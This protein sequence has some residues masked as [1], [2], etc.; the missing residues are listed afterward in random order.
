VT[1]PAP[2]IA[3]AAAVGGGGASPLELVSADVLS[4]T[5]VHLVFS[6][7]VA[8]STLVDPTEFRLSVARSHHAGDTFFQA[9]HYPPANCNCRG[10]YADLATCEPIA[11]GT[12]ETCSEV[13]LAHDYTSYSELGPF[14]QLA[15]GA[16]PSEVIAT[17]SVWI[18]EAS[19]PPDHWPLSLCDDLFLHYAKSSVPVADDAGNALAPF[20][21]TW[22]SSSKNPLRVAG[23]FQEHPLK[24]TNDVMAA[25]CAGNGCSDGFRDGTE[26]DVDCGGGELGWDPGVDVQSCPRCADGSTCIKNAD[27]Q[28]S[29]CHGGHCAAAA[30]NDGIRNGGETAVDCGGPTA[31]ARC[32]DGKHCVVPS[33]CA[34]RGCNPTH[35]LAMQCGPP[36]CNDGASDGDET[37]VDCGGS[38]AG[39]PGDACAQASDCASHLCQANSCVAALP[40]LVAAGDTATACAVTTAGTVACW[41]AN[42]HGEIG[43][44]TTL[45][46][47]G[48]V[49]VPGLTGV[50]KVSVGGA[51]ACAL[52]AAGGVVCWGYNAD[53][54]LGDGTT[55]DRHTPVG[56]VG[57]SSGVLAL[58]VGAVHTCAVTTAGAV[59]CWG[60][61][62][63]GQL[64]DGTKT[65]RHTPVDVVGLTSGVAAVTGGGLHTCALKTN[66]GAVC[67]GDNGYGEI[68][69]GTYFLRKTPVDVLGLSSGVRAISAGDSLTCAVTTAGAVQCWGIPPV[70]DGTMNLRNAPVGVVGLDTGVTDVA[71]GA[72][73]ACALL[74]SGGVDCWGSN[75]FGE[76]G[77]GTMTTQ[78]S[79]VTVV[80]L[81]S[82]VVRIT[83]G[84]F[85]CALTNANHALCWGS[86][87]SGQLGDGT[88][89]SRPVPGAVTNL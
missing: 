79:P 8:P 57:L 88:L 72:G 64:G 21:P 37:G 52:T 17:L 58:T 62:N 78:D 87:N 44:G 7:P 24:V 80:G 25:Y 73:Y 2:A 45:P 29:S 47:L 19:P 69:D 61:N 86:N 75:P 36:S 1:C 70:G 18:G 6:E 3:N 84:A 35:S 53:G 74:S 5:Q 38:C 12:Y 66:G 59:K 89:V 81:A 82:G 39:C 76:L 54:E 40:T 32:A 41:G 83:A 46:R 23:D 49:T 14:E 55:T 10:H 15:P 50:A 20:G 85:T 77:D 33:D 26:S 34:S 51:H 71:V 42:E 31:C 4:P 65:N 9:C 30:C 43:D 63:L 27:C 68:G 11:S 67:W 13:T 48:P 56:V 60:R 16:N 22:V 28:S